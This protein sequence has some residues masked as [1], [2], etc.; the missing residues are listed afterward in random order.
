MSLDPAV[1]AAFS[2]EL[3]E[4][5]KEGGLKDTFRNAAAG[6]GMMGAV[7]GGAHSLAP[8]LSHAPVIQSVSQGATKLAPVGNAV[9]GV[10]RHAEMKNVAAPPIRG[11]APG[12]TGT[13]VVPP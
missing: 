6:L 12:V 13:T 8:S 4:L 9:H 7:A 2:A 11:R 10:A 5:S 1:Y 3:L